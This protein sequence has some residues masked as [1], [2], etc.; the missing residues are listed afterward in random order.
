MQF[1]KLLTNRFQSFHEGVNTAN[2]LFN[3]ILQ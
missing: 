2:Y 3:A 1:Q